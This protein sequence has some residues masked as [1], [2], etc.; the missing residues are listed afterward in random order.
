MRV[1]RARF[2]DPAGEVLLDAG[3]DGGT[4]SSGEDWSAD[5]ASVGTSDTT[6]S[7]LPVSGTPDSPLLQTAR[8]GAAF[9]YRLALP[10]GAYDVTL[11]FAELQGQPAG[12]RV[13]DVM[14]VPE[15]L[16]SAAPMPGQMRACLEVWRKL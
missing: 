4:A 5:F 16:L 8:T 1:E 2:M 3:G 10:D 6:R 15:R 7:A 12:A 13:F 9:G 14:M 11:H